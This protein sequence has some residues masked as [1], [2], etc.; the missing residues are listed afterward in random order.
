WLPPVIWFTAVGGVLLFFVLSRDAKR[1]PLGVASFA[2][3]M[4]VLAW[5]VQVDIQR[6]YSP[7]QLLEKMAKSDGLM[8]ILSGGSYYQKVF[9]LSEAN[10]GHESDENRYVRAYYEFP[11]NFKRR[12]E[13]VAIVGAGSGNDVAAALR[14]GAAHVDA[15]EIDP[16]IV[17]L[18]KAYHPEHPYDDPRVSVVINDARNFFRTA[19]QQY[20]L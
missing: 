3:L 1:L 17:F 11:F 15:I 8:N 4:A 2:L 20:D 19:R 13:R 12:P 9:N 5:P 18:G 14:M 16:V 6:I 10:R 7:Y